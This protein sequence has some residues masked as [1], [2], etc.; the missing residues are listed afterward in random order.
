M[1]GGNKWW[2][3]YMPWQLSWVRSSILLKDGTWE[4]EG[5]KNG[6]N[7]WQDKWEK[8]RW[9]EIH[10]YTYTLKSGEVQN[11]LAS[12]YVEEMEW[13]WHWFKWSTF[14]RKIRKSIKVEFNDEVGERTGS[15]KGG[16]LGCGYDLRPNETPFECLKRM[17]KERSF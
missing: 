4:H 12:I 2:T 15:W 16:C 17:E 14:P 8:V 10:P 3:M 13:R 6:K 9:K 5:R 7:F 1:N 11:R